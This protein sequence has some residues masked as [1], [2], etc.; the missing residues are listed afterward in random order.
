MDVEVVVEIPKGTRNKYEANHETG[1]IWLDRMLFTATR[2]PEDYGF[3]PRT[4]A[5]D[6][7]PLDAMVLLEEPT[8][9][10]CHIKARPVAVFLMRDEHGND[11]KVLCVTSS[12]PRQAS[13]KELEDLPNH[14]LDEIA[15][16]FAIYKT[17]EPGKVAE[18]GGW[19]S[20]EMAERT[21]EE[22]R[23]RYQAQSA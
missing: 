12:D 17:L 4:L 15:H 18:P 13:V 19:H 10:G 7:D 6:G 22:A 14:E 5:E 20:R 16:F 2:Y 8:F 23:H 11:A 1:E 21:I 3:I 9:P